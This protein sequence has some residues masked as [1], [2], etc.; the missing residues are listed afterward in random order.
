MM[1][2][3]RTAHRIDPTTA[4]S[5]LLGP[6]IAVVGVSNGSGN[7]GRTIWRALREQGID[8]VAVHPSG[9]PVEGE[10]CHQTVADVLGPVDAA[11][12]VV[13][14]PASV[15]IVRECA[16]AGIRKVWLFQGLGGGEGAASDE[17][18]RV[19][20]ELGL[21]VVPGACPLMFL[22]PVGWFHRIHRS[23]RRANGAI[24]VEAAQR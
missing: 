4:A 5:M 6:R 22:E 16:A 14:A 23:A 9:A 15:D 21:E 20:G 17:A 12:V 7:F 8:A 19:A 24:R 3:Q 2:R 11:I 1:S 13:G 18:I 10:R